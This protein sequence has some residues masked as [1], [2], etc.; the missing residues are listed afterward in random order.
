ME[1]SALTSWGGYTTISNVVTQ[2]ST[3]GI[4]TY[5]GVIMGHHV[6]AYIYNAWCSYSIWDSLF[7]APTPACRGVL[8]GMSATSDSMLA[9]W[10]IVGTSIAAK[11]SGIL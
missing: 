4:F 3:T 2:I 5:T 11:L 7:K 6:L 9:M 8:W 10:I 1:W